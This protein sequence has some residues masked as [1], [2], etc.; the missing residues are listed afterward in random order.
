MRGNNV[1]LKKYY[2]K[3]VGLNGEDS[4]HPKYPEPVVVL[5]AAAQIQVIGSGADE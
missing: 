2:G 1:D 5:Q 3:Y 4:Y